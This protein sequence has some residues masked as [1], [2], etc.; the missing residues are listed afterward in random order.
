MK[1]FLLTVAGV[2]VALLL[3]F[4]GVPILILIIAVSAAK[5]PAAPSNAILALDLRGGLTDQDSPSPF[6]AFSGSGLSVMSVVS[7]IH[8]EVL[9]TLTTRASTATCSPT[10]TAISATTPSNGAV[11]T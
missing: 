6:A 1:Q 8:A 4:V 11:S 2:F 3:F 10:S 9:T 5:P 7:I